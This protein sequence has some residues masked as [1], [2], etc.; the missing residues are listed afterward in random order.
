MQVLACTSRIKDI[1]QFD[2][3]ASAADKLL[4]TFAMQLEV[5]QQS[6]S[7]WGIQL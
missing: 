1:E 2:S 7:K 6:S 4:R 5:L 3:A